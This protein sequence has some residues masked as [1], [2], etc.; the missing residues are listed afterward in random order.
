MY[1][2]I[3][4]SFPLYPIFS[5]SHAAGILILL[6]GSKKFGMSGYLFL[7]LR[8]LSL[9]MIGFLKKLPLFPILEGSGS[10]DF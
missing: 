7:S 10:F 2:C 1:S 6:E 5:I 8:N 9:L 4:K 3:T